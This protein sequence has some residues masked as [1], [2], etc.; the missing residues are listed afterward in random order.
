MSNINKTPLFFSNAKS[1]IW[2][3]G[4]RKART[5]SHIIL[6]RWNLRLV[7]ELESGNTISRKDGVDEIVGR[8]HK[9]YKKAE[10]TQ[11]YNALES[12]ENHKRQV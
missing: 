7:L 9:I 5:S 12:F 1:N 10:L 11:K 4:A 6:R 2:L 3:T 8:L